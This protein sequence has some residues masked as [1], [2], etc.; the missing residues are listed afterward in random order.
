MTASTNRS[1]Q[2]F[3]GA[4]LGPE[5]ILDIDVL[6]TDQ[7]TVVVVRGEIDLATGQQ[8]RD[9]LLAASRE[10]PRVLVDLSDVTFMDSAG[11]NALVAA[12]HRVP[13]D[14]ELRLAGL[15]PNTRRLLQITGLVDLFATSGEI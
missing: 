12:Y 1:R 8:F 13:P 10:S 3:E 15:R 5:P 11:V 9:A 14:G 4:N 6:A 7:E 2:S